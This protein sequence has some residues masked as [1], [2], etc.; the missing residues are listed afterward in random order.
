M[1]DGG[2]KLDMSEPFTSHLRLDY[3]DPALI[4]YDAPVLHPLVLAAYAFPVFYR[5]EYLSAEKAVPFR[6][7]S[8]IVDCL[9][10]FYFTVRPLAYPF[11]RGE[12]DPNRL[13]V[14]RIFRFLENGVNVFCHS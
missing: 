13:K 2:C 8:P 10:F 6:L 14:S 7:E 11:R 4:A 9:G 1:C 5:T 3:L 12:F